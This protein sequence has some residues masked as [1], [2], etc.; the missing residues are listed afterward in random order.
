[1]IPKPRGRALSPGYLDF[2]REH[3]CCVPG[4][5]V[6]PTVAHHFGKR[7]MGT[8]C[9][10][11]LTVPL[12]D[13]CHKKLHAATLPPPFVGVECSEYFKERALLLLVEY[14]RRLEES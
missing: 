10:D 4:C 5:G 8:K 11:Y 13:L 1:M 7:G 6:E 9:D 14:L 12:C 2:V 3:E